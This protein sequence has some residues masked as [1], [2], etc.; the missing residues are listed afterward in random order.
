MTETLAIRAGESQRTPGG[1]HPFFGAHGAASTFSPSLNAGRGGGGVVRTCGSA[2]IRDAGETFLEAVFGPD[3]QPA[4]EAGEMFDGLLRT[5]IDNTWVEK[6]LE[7][8]RPCSDHP[9]RLVPKT[10]WNLSTVLMQSEDWFDV[11]KV[12]AARCPRDWLVQFC[13]V[14]MLTRTGDLRALSNRR[15]QSMLV[16]GVLAWELA[17]YDPA[18]DTSGGHFPWVVRG[19][20]YRAY[21][22]MLSYWERYA[23][24]VELR[25]PGGT[26]L[27][28]THD[29]DGRFERGGCG[30]IAGWKQAGIART[31]QPNGF[32]APAGMAGPWRYP[33]PK[34]GSTEQ[35][36]KQPK[37][38]WAFVELRLRI[39]GG[40][41]KHGEPLQM[42]PPPARGRGR[43][44]PRRAPNDELDAAVDRLEATGYATAEHLSEELSTAC[45]A[46]QAAAEQQPE[47]AAEQC[48]K[49]ALTADERWAVAATMA[50]ELVARL[51]ETPE[52]QKGTPVLRTQNS[53]EQ[54]TAPTPSAAAPTTP[55]KQREKPAAVTD[56]EWADLCAVRGQIAALQPHD[57]ESSAVAVVHARSALEA[58]ESG[59]PEDAL[60]TASENRGQRMAAGVGAGPEGSGEWRFEEFARAQEDPA[61]LEAL[62]KYEQEVVPIRPRKPPD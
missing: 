46:R 18:G 28:G 41:T 7:R 16:L 49:P 13:G 4:S 48:E 6:R 30:Y 39:G 20:P 10:I 3:W 40:A 2:E 12:F 21:Q 27:F 1:L 35:G 17:E 22:L 36:K 45:P 14:A 44:G 32:T 43:P 60:N 61:F 34:K 33:R 51:K 24:R 26:T 58:A 54:L 59:S 53:G 52:P 29:T 15:A 38:R 50:S 56:E 19:L 5:P 47:G 25:I 8:L 57:T 31:F 37:Q 42:G 9:L 55:S 11:W 23:D 62:R